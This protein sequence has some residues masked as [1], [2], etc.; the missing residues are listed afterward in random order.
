MP[1]NTL[2]GERGQGPPLVRAFDPGWP[3]PVPAPVLLG[4]FEF[5]GRAATAILRRARDER[6]AALGGGIEHSPCTRPELGL[7]P[8][9]YA[10]VMSTSRTIATETFFAWV[11]TTPPTW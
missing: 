8:R 11:S 1:T 7:Q 3:R 10:V 2:V 5:A 9:E 6:P 4:L